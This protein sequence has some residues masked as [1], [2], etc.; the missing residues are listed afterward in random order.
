LSTQAS[1]AEERITQEAS[2]L[3]KRLSMLSVCSHQ[4]ST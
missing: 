4:S 3:E 2:E 1:S